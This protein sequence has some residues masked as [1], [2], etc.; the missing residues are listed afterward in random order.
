[1]HRTA[2]VVAW[3]FVLAG[4]RALLVA[5]GALARGHTAEGIA[6][7]SAGMVLLLG[8]AL[9]VRAVRARARRRSRCVRRPRRAAAVRRR[10]AVAIAGGGPMSAGG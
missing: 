8:G 7:V 10:L 1:M 3:L 6:L 2:L 4:A 5:P 9:S